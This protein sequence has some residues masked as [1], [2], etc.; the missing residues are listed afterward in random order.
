[1][2]RA[3]ALRR[4]ESTIN[5]ADKTKLSCRNIQPGTEKQCSYKKK[6]HPEEDNDFHFDGALF[7]SF[8]KAAMQALQTRHDRSGDVIPNP[9]LKPNQ[10]HPSLVDAHRSTL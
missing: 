2:F 4:S 9:N 8:S 5:P 3:L 1:M 7:W 10:R 6:M